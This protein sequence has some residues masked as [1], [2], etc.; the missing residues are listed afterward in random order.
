VIATVAF[1]MGKAFIWV[2]P[3]TCIQETGHA[4]SRGAPILPA[5]NLEK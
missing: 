1:G 5:K 2:L 4:G 3:M